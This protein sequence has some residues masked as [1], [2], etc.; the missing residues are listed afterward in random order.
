[1][2]GASRAA[3]GCTAKPQSPEHGAKPEKQKCCKRLCVDGNRGREGGT[4]HACIQPEP[5]MKSI[6][7]RLQQRGTSLSLPV[8]FYFPCSISIYLRKMKLPCIM[9]A[10][11][12]R[13]Y[14]NHNC[15]KCLI[16]LPPER[17][18]CSNNN[19]SQDLTRSNVI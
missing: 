16:Q 14:G 13:S 3:S 2:E 15:K 5:H 11:E 10:M 18:N 17:M 7:F 4:A 1:M 8:L 19:S 9:H 12:M 6:S